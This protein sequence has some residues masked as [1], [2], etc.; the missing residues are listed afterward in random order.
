MFDY[1]TAKW[2]MDALNDVPKFAVHPAPA[3]RRLRLFVESSRIATVATRL[4]ARH[5]G[6]YPVKRGSKRRGA[7]LPVP[8]SKTEARKAVCNREAAV[9]DQMDSMAVR[10]NRTAPR[11]G[12]LI[13]ESARSIVVGVLLSQWL[14]R[15]EFL[16]R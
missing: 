11:L 5:D 9:F 12:P 13:V 6:I 14:I 7:S 2:A 3:P 15:F 10:K 4:F 16:L 1:A 8:H